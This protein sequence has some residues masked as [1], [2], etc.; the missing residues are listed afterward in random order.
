M[1]RKSPG[2]LALLVAGV[3]LLAP[4][5]W[6][7][8]IGVIDQPT[9]G[10]TVSG[11]VKVSGF[12]LDFNTLDNEDVDHIDFLMDGQIVA[13]AVGRGLPST[14]IYG[15]TRPD[16]H[17]AFPD[18]PN[19]L[20]SGFQANVDTTK[21]INGVHLLSVRVTDNLGASRVIGTRTVQI[22]NNGANLPPFGQIDFP[23]DK[24]SLFCTTINVGIPSPCTPDIC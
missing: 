21:L 9:A 12:V 16:V 22:I 7:Q 10:Q 8:P 17:A 20:F 3:W 13:G 14:A 6:A 2:L 1:L 11:V 24:A 19:S 4:S 5:V 18:V 15:T 23:L